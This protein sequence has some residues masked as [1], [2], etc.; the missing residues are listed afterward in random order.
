MAW[1]PKINVIDAR[2]LD[3]NILAFIEANQVEAMIWANGGIVLKVFQQLSNSI[4]NRSKPIYPSLAIFSESTA[5]QFDGDILRCVYQLRIESVIYSNVAAEAAG[6]SKIYGH[7]LESMLGN[8]TGAVLTGGAA[9]MTA[10]LERL[11]T[12][13]TDLKWTKG[14]SNFYREIET[15]ATYSIQGQA[16]N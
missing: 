15:R 3:A 12:N 16:Q 14:T 11:D 7:A 13:Y 8:V 2:K 10:S 6:L 5:T 9:S 1:T 4:A